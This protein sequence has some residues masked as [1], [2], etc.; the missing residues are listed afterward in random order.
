[1][2]NGSGATMS[3][4]SDLAQAP[5]EASRVPMI[6]II[7]RQRL[8]RSCIQKILNA[9]L[10]G[11]EI[12]ELETSEDLHLATGRDVRLIAW[13]IGDTDIF[14]PVIKDG[15]ANFTKLY[16]NAPVALLSNREDETDRKSVV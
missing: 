2:V 13:N 16:P 11:F 3:V 7:E 5:H 9:E 6:V 8:T 4:L 10:T 1:M 14:D 12:L 15:I